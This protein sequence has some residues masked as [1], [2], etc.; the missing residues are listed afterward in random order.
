MNTALELIRTVE[1]NG[2][3]LRVEDGWLVIA[4]EDAAM[5]VLEE[6][7]LHKVE[8]IDLLQ[9]DGVPP[10]DPAEWRKQFARWLDSACVRH[11]RCFGGVGR[12]HVAFC[13]WQA[14]RGGVSCNRDTFELLLK[15]SGFLMGEVAGVVL[16]SGL[17]FRGDAEAV[18]LRT[19]AG[20]KFPSTRK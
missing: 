18:G 11:R 14:R 19:G 7:R 12:L 1:A 5:P 4:P 16:V 20:G 10:N 9:P 2:G 8:I 6:L 3:Q 17:T 13:E 15:E